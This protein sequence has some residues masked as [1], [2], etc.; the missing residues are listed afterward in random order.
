MHAG[1]HNNS[2][3]VSSVLERNGIKHIVTPT[4]WGTLVRSD[5]GNGVSRVYNQVPENP[6]YPAV[7]HDMESEFRG[8]SYN[9]KY[10]SHMWAA[11]D[12]ILHTSYARG[13]AGNVEWSEKFRGPVGHMFYGD[14]RGARRTISVGINF[15]PSLL[16]PYSYTIAVEN[17][18]NS[19]IY[20]GSGKLIK[21]QDAE[22][23]KARKYDDVVFTVDNLAVSADGVCSSAFFT[24][25]FRSVIEHAPWA[26]LD[27]SLAHR[28]RHIAGDVIKRM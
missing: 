26:E 14:A 24:A 21:Y 9:N 2:Y 11:A 8:S 10:G 18:P 12:A 19:S 17:E 28:A 1:D 4:D 13:A 5:L 6:I 22:M 3:A 27:N 20:D 15:R 25:L 23:E 16:G 7:P